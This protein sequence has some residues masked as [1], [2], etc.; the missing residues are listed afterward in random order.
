MTDIRRVGLIGG[1]VIGAGW[2]A[3]CLLNGLDVDLFDPDPE[4]GR[5]MEAVLGNARRAYRRLF[6]DAGAQEG[7]LR[8]VSSVEPAV[9]AADFVQESLPERLDLKQA[10]LAAASRAAGDDVIFGSSTSG[11]LPSDMQKDMAGADRLVVG[12]PFNPVYL[13]PLVEVCGGALTSEDAKRKAAA[14]YR[15]IGMHPLML[16]QEI[17]GFVADRLMEALWREALWLVHDG[18]A[19]TEEVDEAIRFGPGLRWSFMG[20]FLTYRIAGGEAGMRHFMAQFGPALKW[21]WTKLTD[22][23]ELTDAFVDRIA[24]QSDDQAGSMSIREL[25]RLRDNCLVSVLSAL[26]TQGYGAGAT[27]DRHGDLLRDRA[28]AAAREG[29]ID[30][31]MPLHL[32]DCRV[33]S[34]W[35]DHSGHMTEGRCLQV[36]GAASDALLRHVGVDVADSHRGKGYR[37]AESHVV[38]IGDAA[39]GEP[40]YVTTQVLGVE[41]TRLQVFH[42]LYK[43][44]DD[45]PVATAEQML[46]HVDAGSRR[47]T[48]A[49]DRVLD[50]L[51]AIAAAQKFLPKP[52][53]AGRFVGA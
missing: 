17:D 26:R 3:R 32:H 24:G 8:L 35:T 30:P 37:T 7:R 31:S 18:I 45:T 46:I 25:E 10:V 36:F 14:F 51:N 53:G 47:P 22:V 38:T 28:Q 2:A 39:L 23:P 34:D 6:P 13:M 20:T 15:S 11:L 40:L 27:V 48:S 4:I 21:P 42:T 52:A 1:G 33:E 41:A 29:G 16:K 44:D 9:E 19:T 5:K 43:R 50:G 12:H 49:D